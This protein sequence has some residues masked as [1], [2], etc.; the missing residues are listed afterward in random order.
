MTRIDPA[1]LPHAPQAGA[2]GIYLH[3]PFCA[4]IC[5]YCNFNRGLFDEG[6]ASR[7]VDAL[8]TEI[9]AAA[10]GAAVD[11]VY[12]G[13]GTPSLMAAAEIDRVIAACR[14]AFALAQDTEITLE[15]NPESADPARLEAFRAAG[16]N[17]LSLGVQSFDDEDLERLG[18]VHSAARARG[19][20]EAA[21]AAGFDNISL[22]LMMW[23]P[24]Q[25][26]PAW[27]ATVEALIEAAPDHASLYLLEI[28]PNAPLR[29]EMARRAWQT[30]PDDVAADMYLL[31]LDR[32]ERAGYVQY[33][34]SN[35]ARGG[36]FARHN[37]KYWTCGEW[38]GFGCGAHGTR[39]RTRWRNVAATTDYLALVAS[40]RAPRAETRV[41]SQGDLLV[42]ALIMGLRLAGGVDVGALGALAECDLEGRHRRDLQPFVDAALVEVAGGRWRLT[43]H[44]M[45][46]ANEILSVFV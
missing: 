4:A 25:D 33:E 29:D 35:V 45:L 26:L 6:L 7:Y 16:I 37:L 18:R 12:F 30:A 39:H 22:D 23:L 38:F 34:I 15:V 44:G 9:A 20:I 28:Y 32:L 19:A 2:A 11:T 1:T 40:G 27:L 43:R 41:L 36:R 46:L 14:R 31:G 13:G 8:C 21:R 42:E 24:S 17:R 3:Y 5:H 10:D